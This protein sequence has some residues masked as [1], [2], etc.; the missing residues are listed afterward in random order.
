MV[1]EQSIKINIKKKEE[2]NPSTRRVIEFQRQKQRLLKQDQ[3]KGKFKIANEPVEK[4]VS[5]RD[6]NKM[7]RNDQIKQDRQG[8]RENIRS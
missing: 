7:R 2:K 3:D 1:Q 4:Q 6:R 5:K 8:G